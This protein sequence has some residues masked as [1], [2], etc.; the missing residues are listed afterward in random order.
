MLHIFK[1]DEGFVLGLNMKKRFDQKLSK[2]GQ[3]STYWSNLI[4]HDHCASVAVDTGRDMPRLLL[5][6]HPLFIHALPT[7]YFIHT[8]SSLTNSVTKPES[9]I[10]Y[11][12]NKA[13]GSEI[14]QGLR[15]VRCPHM[16]HM[17][18]TPSFS[19]HGFSS[20]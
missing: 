13:S 16:L 6:I 20:E 10:P 5:H 9:C 7:L 12:S 8:I 4:I 14:R 1:I 11:A 17:K 3:S 18:H 19:Y 2:I 15:L